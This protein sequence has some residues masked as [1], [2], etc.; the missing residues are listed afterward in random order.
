MQKNVS[1]PKGFYRMNTLGDNLRMK[2]TTQNGNVAG[3]QVDVFIK[4]GLRVVKVQK[5]K[6]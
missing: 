1:L 5:D 3:A 2:L 4:A 6:I